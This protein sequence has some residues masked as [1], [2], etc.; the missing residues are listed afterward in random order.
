MCDRGFNADELRLNEKKM[1]DPA[2]A[3]FAPSFG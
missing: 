3:G 2:A 1:S